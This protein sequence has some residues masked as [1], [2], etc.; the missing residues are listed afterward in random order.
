MIRLSVIIPYYQKKPGILRRAL[1]SVALQD[2]PQNV[3]MDVIVVDDGS[4]VPAKSEIDG[5]DFASPH[6]LIIIEQPNGGVSTARNTG[7]RN[8]PHGTEY[9]AFLD[10]DDIWDKKHIR[11]SITYLEMGYDY[12]FCDCRRIGNEE[13]FFS[14]RNYVQFLLSSGSK[15]IGDRVYEV[16]NESFFKFSLRSRVSMMP[17]I[18][19]RRSV[20]PDLRFD[21][22]LHVAGEDCLFV[23][24]LL[25]KCKNICCSLDE[26]VTCADGINIY[27][28]RYSW[29]DP[30]HLIRHM[31]ILLALYRFRRNL[32]LSE[33]DNNF[34]SRRIKKVRQAFAFLSLRY[35]LKYRE[36]WPD[37]LTKMT[38]NDNGFKVWY[39]LYVLYV[40]ICF[41]LRLYDPLEDLWCTE[42]VEAV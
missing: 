15:I 26:L 32:T 9:I 2:L 38:R 34:F 16:E 35:F 42:T 33:D 36:L 28:G 17:A 37:E 39:P 22:S 30:G 6:N 18:V 8:V 10:S 13:S 14:E 25:T 41:P 5:L 27:A 3:R 7:L 21:T 20:A 24:Q 40:A 12:Y 1:D 11:Q 29:E 4:P 31:G 23:F 19:Y